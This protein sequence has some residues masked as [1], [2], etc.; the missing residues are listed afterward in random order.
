MSY[1]AV[2]QKLTLLPEEYLSDVSTFLDTLLNKRRNH[3]L[4]VTEK[5]QTRQ[6]REAFFSLAGNIDIDE[7]A[8]VDLRKRSDI[9]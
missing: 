8:V 1:I 4:N 9:K 7:K 3:S 6:N 2:E 5:E